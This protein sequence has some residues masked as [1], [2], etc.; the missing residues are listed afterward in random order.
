[1]NRR[2]FAQSLAAIVAAPALPLAAVS[3]PVA[4]LTPVSY[5]IDPALW[6]RLAA[7]VKVPL[8]P[9]VLQS[10]L[11]LSASEAQRIFFEH[12]AKALAQSNAPL[13]TKAHLA[14]GTG[15]FAHRAADHVTDALHENENEGAYETS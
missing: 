12:G 9:Q 6:T 2:Q 4:P 8:S 15:N 11:G 10:Q 14:D 1:M 13:R 3:A 5:G 7:K